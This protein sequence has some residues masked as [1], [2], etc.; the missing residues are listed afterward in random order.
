MRAASLRPPRTRPSRL[1][2]CERRRSSHVM[3]TTMSD[4]TNQVSWRALRIVTSS[5]SRVSGVRRTY[6]KGSCKV[7]SPV[8]AVGRRSGRRATAAL[9]TATVAR[10]GRPAPRLVKRAGLVACFRAPR[11]ALASSAPR[12]LKTTQCCHRKKWTSANKDD[13][14]DAAG[15]L[16]VP[17]ATSRRTGW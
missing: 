10:R 6:D 4:A 2:F 14:G 9:T 8:P 3:P 16:V 5:Y 17:T 15:Q 12:S 7:P 11:S 1:S 13:V